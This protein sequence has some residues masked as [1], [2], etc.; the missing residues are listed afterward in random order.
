MEVS[1]EFKGLKKLIFLDLQHNPIS[2]GQHLIQP[3]GGL[4]IK[5]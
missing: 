3:S 2:P 1:Q 4:K 5:F